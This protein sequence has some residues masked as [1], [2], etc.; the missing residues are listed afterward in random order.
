MLSC[1]AA[2]PSRSIVTSWVDTRTV[3]SERASL[4]LLFDKYLPVCLEK[5]KKG[6]KA[7]TPVPEVTVIHMVLYLLECLLT[8]QTVPPDSPRDLYELYFVFA[9]TWAFGGAMFQDQV[10]LPTPQRL[11]PSFILQLHPLGKY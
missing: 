8:P 7:I 5:V 3:Q 11:L 4:M 10:R 2:H 6:F 1:S 9:C